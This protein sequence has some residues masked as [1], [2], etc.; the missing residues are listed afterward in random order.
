MSAE[1]TGWAVTAILWA[2]LIAFLITGSPEAG[3]IVAAVAGAALAAVCAVTA[4]ERLRRAGR[5]IDQAIANVCQPCNGE[6][7]RCICPGKCGNWLCGAD[8]TGTD[9]AAFDRELA[10][11]LRQDKGQ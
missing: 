9:R 10:E 5:D 6:A 2:A 4:R 7:G 3:I 11:W 8:D 1:D